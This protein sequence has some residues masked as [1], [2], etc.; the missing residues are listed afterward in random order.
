ME[1]YLTHQP[2]SVVAIHY[3]LCV[4]F[5][6]TAPFCN[7]SNKWANMMGTF[8]VQML[9]KS[10]SFMGTQN[11]PSLVMLLWPQHSW[12]PFLSPLLSTGSLAAN[13][14]GQGLCALLASVKCCALL[15][16]GDGC[17]WSEP[18]PPLCP[19]G[20]S[21]LEKLISLCAWNPLLQSKDYNPPFLVLSELW[22][23]SADIFPYDVTGGQ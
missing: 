10:P 18:G 14:L 21:G 17:C 22:V 3:C 9:A 4:N 16:R 12:Q 13:A 23:L 11:E 8:S 6:W 15:G 2:C 5:L 1:V 19:W 20:L 7:A